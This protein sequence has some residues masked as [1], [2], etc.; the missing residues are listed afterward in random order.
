ME[1]AATLLESV[2][3][4]MLTD[5]AVGALSQMLQTTPEQVREYLGNIERKE[6]EEHIT[7]VCNVAAILADKNLLPEKLEDLDMDALEDPEL[8][9]KI[10][11]EIL[12]NEKL[13]EF[14]GMVAS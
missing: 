5:E 7:T 6:M 3:E 12:K 11:E 10:M 8:Q 1:T 4:E 9:E 2:M 14:L 13:A